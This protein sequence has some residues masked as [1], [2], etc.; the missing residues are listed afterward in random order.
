MSFVRQPKISSQWVSE[1]WHVPIIRQMLK[2]SKQWVS[3]LRNVP[4]IRQPYLMI[5]VGTMEQIENFKAFNHSGWNAHSNA[6]KNAQFQNYE[7]MVKQREGKMVVLVHFETFFKI[8]FNHGEVKQTKSFS[9]VHSRR[10]NCKIF[11]KH[12]EEKGY[13]IVVAWLSFILFIDYKF[14]KM[15]G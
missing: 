4:V 7:T 1:Q 8:V 15:G 10:C 3:A 12:G 5:N 9:R 13:R 6:C 2:M 14:R 11:F